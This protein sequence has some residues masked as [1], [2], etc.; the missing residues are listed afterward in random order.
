MN[1]L[2]SVIRYVIYT[3][4]MGLKFKKID[5]KDQSMWILKC[6][7]NSDWSGDKVSRKSVSGWIEYVQYNPLAWGSLQK[8]KTSQSFS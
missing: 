1:H 2:Y 6:Y 7:V 5:D 8:Q 4:S 3:K